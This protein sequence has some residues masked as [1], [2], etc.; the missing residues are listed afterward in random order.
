MFC[1]Q[2][3]ERAPPTQTPWTT[4]SEKAT[5]ED[6]AALPNLLYGTVTVML[7]GAGF[8]TVPVPVGVTVTV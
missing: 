1:V 6:V 7:T 8:V 5:S 3:R 2:G 4:I